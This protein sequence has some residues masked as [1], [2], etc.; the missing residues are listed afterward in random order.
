MLGRRTDGGDG[1][2]DFTELQLIQ[3]RRLSGSVQ[4]DH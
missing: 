4:A 2:H 1:G 3:D